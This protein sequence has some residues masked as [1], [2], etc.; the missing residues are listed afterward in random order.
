VQPLSGDLHSTAQQA[1][2]TLKEAQLRLE[3]REGE[4]MQNL[5]YA[6]ID[7]RKLVGDVD[8]RVGPLMSSI[9]NFMTSAR[10]SISPDSTLYVQLIRTLKDFQATADSIRELADYLERH[11]NSLL[12]GKSSP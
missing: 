1:T 2:R 6:L 8:V 12:T 4:P 5:N 11:P 7:A 3:L 9:I 10:S